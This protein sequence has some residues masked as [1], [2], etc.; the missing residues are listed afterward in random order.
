M[1]KILFIFVCFIISILVACPAPEG[2]TKTDGEPA[3]FPENLQGTWVMSPFFIDNLTASDYAD[4]MKVIVTKREAIMSGTGRFTLISCTDSVI[5]VRADGVPVNQGCSYVVN[6][7]V[8]TATT[9]EGVYPIGIEYTDDSPKTWTKVTATEQTSL[10]VPQKLQGAWATELS[11]VESQPPSAYQPNEIFTITSNKLIS[12]SY[13][14]NIVYCSDSI[15]KIIYDIVPPAGAIVS[16]Q[17]S[18]YSIDTNNVLTFSEI[19]GVSPTNMEYSEGNPVRWKKVTTE[20][21]TT[22][23]EFPLALRGV[24]VPEDEY[25]VGEPASYYL[26]EQKVIIN[27]SEMSFFSYYLNDVSIYDLVFCT[28]TIIKVKDRD[29][30]YQPVFIQG[31]SYV[32]DQ[33]G[34]LTFSTMLDLGVYPIGIEGVLLKKVE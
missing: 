15:I 1:R 3:E 30:P 9:I 24:W 8:L 27:S 20:E 13:D 25:A 23:P 2:G 28:D 29:Y 11:Y 19:Y 10:V 17:G 32:I 26:D 12:Y 22:P 18:S 5:T 4:N 31:S 6:S 34:D 7:N 14:A 21:P 33:T 16:V